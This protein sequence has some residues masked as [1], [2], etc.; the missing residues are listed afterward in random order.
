MPGLVGGAAGNTRMPGKRSPPG[1]APRYGERMSTAPPGGPRFGGARLR[2][3]TFWLVFALA[4][5]LLVTAVTVPLA[6][7]GRASN[8]GTS[9]EN[10][11]RPGDKLLYAAGTQVRRGDVVLERVPSGPGTFA[12]IVRRVIGLPGDRVSCCDAHGRVVVDGKALDEQ[13]LYPGDAP[14]VSRF[15]VRLPPGQLW[16]MGDHRLIAEDSRFRGLA[17]AADIAGRVIAV[18]SGVSFSPVR[19]PP[20]FV[21]SGLAPADSRTSL[22]IGWLSAAAAAAAALLGFLVFGII[23]LVLRRRRRRAAEQPDR[24]LEP[25]A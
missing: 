23:R 12:L 19:T 13:Y 1:T 5:A 18:I 17:P 20:V 16:L 25:H 7:L 8:A 6:S 10:T 15:D 3:A 11:I 22:P 21:T 2:R 24:A 14:S 9:M 4:V